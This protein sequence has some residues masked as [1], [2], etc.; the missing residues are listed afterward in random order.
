MVKKILFITLS[1]MGDVILTLPVLDY[2]KDNFP[3]SELTCLVG[4]RPKEI[5]ENNPFIDKLIIYDKRSRLR[6]KVK[7]FFKLKSEAFDV[8][9]DLRNTMYGALLPA[10][11]K[12]SPFLRMPKSIRH[13]KE[14]NLFRLQKALGIKKPLISIKPRM[15]F[16]SRENKEYIDNLLRENGLNSKE[17]IILVSY[18]AGGQTR[19][20]NTQSFT[21]L[22]AKLSADYKVILIGASTY[23]ATADYICQNNTGNILDFSGLTNLAQL[24]YLL[25]RS[26]LL[27]TTDT[28]TLQ[29]AS[30]LDRPIV[31]L[32]G[33]S[34]EYRYG[35]WS[36]KQMVVK[37]E[38]FCRP[39]KQPDCRFKTIECMKLIKVEDVLHA[40]SD[41]MEGK[42]KNSDINLKNDFKRIL[43][44]RTDRIGD[45]LL[46]TPVIKALRAAYPQAYIAMMVSPYAKEIVDGNPF[47]DDV[48]IYDKDGKHKSWKRSFRFALNLKKKKFDLCLVL[49]PTNR[50]HL[51]TYFAG[52]RKRVGYDRKLGF[53]LSDKVVHKKQTGQFHELE[54]N[55]ELVNYLG[56]E[57]RDKTL[58]MPIKKESELFIEGLLK[59]KG[60]N[61]DD[62]LLAIHPAASCISKIWPAERFALVADKLAEKYGFKILLIAGPKDLKVAEEVANKIH[63]LAINLAGKTSV[64]QLASLL[65]RCA[66]FISNDSGPVHVASA[67]NTPVISIF[68]RNQAGLSPK[69]W[70][71]IGEKSRILHKEVGCIACLAHNC[72]KNFSCLRAISVEDVLKLVE[73]MKLS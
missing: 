66:L 37:K 14:K 69:R 9:I 68:G 6:E 17:R 22:C 43:I 5:F 72:K 1:N 64:S 11:Y 33:P 57:P 31:G 50:V 15:L 48:V 47:L 53:L 19:R 71:P 26:S 34:D 63:R 65:K 58:Y 25:E 2:L 67:V 46:S 10:K 23:K 16:V 45:V 49:H 29:L 40:V 28:G 42:I 54:Y 24:S 36:S 7:L 30:Y 61:K 70:G 51:I 21:D 35:P 41:L 55:L 39:C 8:V 32:F 3:K 13:M 59:R 4:P 20:W 56:I 60:V 27:I 12:T 18:G 44:V 38:I 62:R 73:S 52:I